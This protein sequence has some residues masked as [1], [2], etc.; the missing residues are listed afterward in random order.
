ME[1][2]TPNSYGI[3]M[4]IGLYIVSLIF[5]YV[6]VQELNSS[7]IITLVVVVIAMKIIEVILDSSLKREK[8]KISFINFV[9]FIASAALIYFGVMLNME[10]ISKFIP[11]FKM[12]MG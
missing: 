12:F 11:Y 4:A 2:R 6:Q 5:N 9:R 1:T 8:T 10:F 7:G 3:G